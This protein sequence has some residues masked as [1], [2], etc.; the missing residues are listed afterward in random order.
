ML[1]WKLLRLLFEVVVEDDLLEL[2]SEQPT[3][4]AP[5]NAAIAATPANLRVV[6]TVPP[7]TCAQRG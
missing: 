1:T 4:T 2:S 5:I 3:A 6:F 7:L